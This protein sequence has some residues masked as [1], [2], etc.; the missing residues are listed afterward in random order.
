MPSPRL[1][2]FSAVKI[3][4][5]LLSSP[6][7]AVNKNS[8]TMSFPRLAG[9]SAVNIYCDLLLSPRLAENLAVNKNIGTMSSPRLAGFSA[10]KEG[11]G[12]CFLNLCT[13]TCAGGKGFLS[14]AQYNINRG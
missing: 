3:Y 8:G 7:L 5:D 4:C 1:A 9:F 10:V 12:G 2:G 11:G 13:K 6:R 14:S